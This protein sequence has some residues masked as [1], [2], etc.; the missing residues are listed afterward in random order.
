MN[1]QPNGL[2]LALFI[3]FTISIIFVALYVAKQEQIK[4]EIE[5]NEAHYSPMRIH[6]KY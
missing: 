6:Q 2:K 3:C 4:K 5:Y 1:E